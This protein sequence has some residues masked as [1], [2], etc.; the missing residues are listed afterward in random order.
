MSFNFSPLFS[1]WFLFCFSYQ[2]FDTLSRSHEALRCEDDWVKVRS[3]R[4]RSLSN[5]PL[6]S[7]VQSVLSRAYQYER[8]MINDFERIRVLHDYRTGNLPK[9]VCFT[10]WKLSFLLASTLRAYAFVFLYVYPVLL[11]PLFAFYATKYGNWAGI[12]IAIV[13]SFMVRATSGREEK[14]KNGA[15]SAFVSCFPTFNNITFSLCRLFRCIVCKRTWKIRL[16]T[17]AL[18]I[19]LWAYFARSSTTCYHN[20]CE[21]EKS[22]FFSRFFFCLLFCSC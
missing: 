18:T 19:F 7:F 22:S 5:F 12:F 8:Y 10:L 17:L 13:A 14:L 2:S 6:L 16:T 15:R 11:A 20:H 1:P 4:N 21:C 3:K 9:E